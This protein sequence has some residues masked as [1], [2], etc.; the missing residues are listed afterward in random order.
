MPAWVTN[1]L[2]QVVQN[3]RYACVV[4][5][6]CPVTR[7][8]HHVHTRQ[9]LLVVTKA[10]PGQALE[11]VAVDRPRRRLARYGQPQ[12]RATA[13]VARRYRHKI[14]PAVA[15]PLGKCPP[16]LIRIQEPGALGKARA[17]HSSIMGTTA[18]GLWRAVP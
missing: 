6:L 15:A 18:R 10:F 13:M 8:N 3:S 9:F 17:T 1:P 5:G 4:Q 14:T 11:P 16:V 12:A 2:P 7:D